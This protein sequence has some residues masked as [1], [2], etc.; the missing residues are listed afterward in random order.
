MRDPMQR[1]DYACAVA[2]VCASMA[3]FEGVVAATC[4][5]SSVAAA[6][7]VNSTRWTIAGAAAGIDPDAALRL[8]NAT[9]PE[10]D[11]IGAEVRAAHDAWVERRGGRWTAWM[12]WA[13]WV[14]RWLP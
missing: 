4:P 11:P 9:R 14:A 7:M 12:A 8:L 6:A 3:M 13:A 10:P 5:D 1:Q 2:Q